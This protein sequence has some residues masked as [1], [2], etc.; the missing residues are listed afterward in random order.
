MIHIQRISACAIIFALFS[1]A[2]FCFSQRLE[3]QTPAIASKSGQKQI[4]TAKVQT[5]LD[6]GHKAQGATP[7]RLDEAERFYGDAL[8]LSRES[9]D[10]KGESKSLLNLGNIYSSR[11]DLQGALNYYQQALSVCRV[12]DD[13]FGQSEAIRNTAI[14]FRTTQ[15]DKA[16][17]NCRQALALDREIGDKTGELQS[18]TMLGSLL[19]S[20]NR[21][22]EA[23]EA[24]NQALSLAKSTGNER[25][26][27]D[28]LWYL[29][30]MIYTRLSATKGDKQAISEAKERF[31]KALI[32]YDKLNDFYDAAWTNQ[33]IAGISF[34]YEGLF[35]EARPYYLRAISLYGKLPDKSNSASTLSEL[36]NSGYVSGHYVEALKYHQEALT[37]YNK[38]GD[39]PSQAVEMMRIAR[40]YKL[41]GQRSAAFDLYRRALPIL[42]QSNN[43]EGLIDDLIELHYYCYW[44]LGDHAQAKPYLDKL[45]PLLQRPATGNERSRNLYKLGLIYSLTED[46]VK[47]EKTWEESLAEGVKKGEPIQGIVASLGTVEFSLGHLD[48]ALDYYRQSL[49]L[50]NKSGTEQVRSSILCN[51]AEIDETRGNKEEA[52]TNLSEA[53]ELVAKVRSSFNGLSEAKSSFLSS[54]FRTYQNYLSLLL[55]LNRPKDAFALAQK[56]KARSLL[57]ILHDGKIQLS[58]P[59][60]QEEKSQ[61]K[62]LRQKSDALNFQLV[63][64]GVQNEIGSRKRAD[65]IKLQIAVAER[66]L[67]VFEDGLYARHPDIAQKRVAKTIEMKDIS[68]FLPEDTALLE[69]VTLK[70][71]KT[72]ETVLFVV[73]RKAGAPI[74]STYILPLKQTSLIRQVDAFRN[75]CADPRKPYRK[76]AQAL[77][78]TLIAPAQERL[79]GKKRLLICPD[80]VLWDVPFAALIADSGTPSSPSGKDATFLI[81]QFEIDYA[82]S[83][84]GAEAELTLQGRVD[85]RKPTKTILAFADPYFGGELRFGDRLPGERP[86]PDAS[87]P[88]PDASRPIPDASRPIPDAS[89]PIPDASRDPLQLLRGGYLRELPGTLQEAKAIKADFTDAVIY[90]KKT[91]QEATVKKEATDYRYLHFATHGFFNDAA[92]L[93]SAIILAQPDSKSGEDG[94]LTAREIFDLNL[95]ADLVVLSACNTARGEKRN[96]EGLIGLTWALF[97]AGAPTQVVSQWAVN[98]AGT[99]L[100]MQHFYSNLT[101]KRMAKGDALRQASLSLL[102][103]GSKLQSPTHKYDHPYYWAPFILIGNWGR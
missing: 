19:N 42:E 80:G 58:G 67:Q 81:R 71:G 1:H 102:N 56:M 96:G 101:R 84:T 13:K 82:Y 48:K 47:A 20:S 72:D 3:A 70:A 29:G 22:S 65:V 15:P 33:L 94:F 54:Y 98:D 85:R 5:L 49:K 87:R 97:A 51:I 73:T 9:H 27:A 50:L 53:V 37:I 62:L 90:T 91:A 35:E 44:Q 12:A 11:S 74:L 79:K 31:K 7:P 99:G 83:A 57:D 4:P 36:A 89:R 32:I 14:L 64:E 76:E 16:I 86:I 24:Y 103:E 93:L 52:A 100:L 61:E 60:S 68:K 55:S 23:K 25:A 34:Y 95:S 2:L 69:Y 10:A 38:I 28:V 41:I 8:I 17:Q 75:A 30:S 77:Y 92:P 6:E 78:Q 18:L 21:I 43:V 26:E 63:R 46:Y 66:D 59:L 45:T 40:I 39:M 88:I